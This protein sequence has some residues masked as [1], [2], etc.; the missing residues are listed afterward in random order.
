MMR[1]AVKLRAFIGCLTEQQGERTLQMT[2]VPLLVR[3]LDRSR[4]K[5]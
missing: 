5:A 4:Q 3:V 1:S 2:V